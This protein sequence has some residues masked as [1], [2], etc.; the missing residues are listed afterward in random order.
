[1]YLILS[2]W[3]SPVRFIRLDRIHCIHCCFPIHVGP[4]IVADLTE[5]LPDELDGHN[6]KGLRHDDL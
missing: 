6:S 4:V 5:V 3:N 1:M 2:V